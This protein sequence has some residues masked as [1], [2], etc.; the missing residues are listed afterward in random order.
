MVF[1]KGEHLN[2]IDHLE[3]TKYSVFILHFLKNHKRYLSS[4]LTKTL[5]S[6]FSIR[7]KIHFENSFKEHTD[8]QKDTPIHKPTLNFDNIDKWDTR[9]CPGN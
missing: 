3:F 1:E 9:I 4:V 7:L 6:A 5:L 8:T 2:A